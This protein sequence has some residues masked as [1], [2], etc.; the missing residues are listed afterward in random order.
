[1]YYFTAVRYTIMLLTI[2]L[3]TNARTETSGGTL[4]IFYSLLLRKRRSWS[5]D[6]FFAILVK[7][8]PIFI[9]FKKPRSSETLIEQPRGYLIIPSTARGNTS[10]A[11]I[12]VVNFCYRTY[13]YSIIKIYWRTYSPG[14]QRFDLISIADINT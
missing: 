6:E 14:C 10:V 7:M 4:T 2:V 11:P 12:S 9:R 3:T 1:M 13:Y 8:V 5:G